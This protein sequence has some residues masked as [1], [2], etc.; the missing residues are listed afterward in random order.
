MTRL[1]PRGATGFVMPVRK[2]DRRSLLA[3]VHEVARRE[4]YDVAETVTGDADRVRTYEVRQLNSSR[5]SD[6]WLVIHKS[7]PLVAVVDAEPVP[8]GP[9]RIVDWSPLTAEQVRDVGWWLMSSDEGTAQPDQV[10]LAALDPVEIEQI[11]YWRPQSV[12][13]VAF[14]SWD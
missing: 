9:L 5:A 4:G 3:V 2:P 14:N 1:L 10:Q 13:D 12:A 7:V 6:V 8:L 11:N